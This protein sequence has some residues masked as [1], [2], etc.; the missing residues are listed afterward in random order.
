[1]YATV[2]RQTHPPLSIS[3]VVFIPDAMDIYSPCTPPAKNPESESSS[4]N[5]TPLKTSQ[6]EMQ[7]IRAHSRQM[8]ASYKQWVATLKAKTDQ[9]VRNRYLT[10]AERARGDVYMSM[11][12]EVPAFYN[13][14]GSAETMIFARRFPHLMPRGHAEMEEFERRVWFLGV[15]LMQGLEFRRRSWSA[16]AHWP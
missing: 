1:M 3:C 16:G 11:S 6:D 9:S 13:D 14:R 7:W 12:S 8:E 15:S 4:S 5:Q 2:V 10:A